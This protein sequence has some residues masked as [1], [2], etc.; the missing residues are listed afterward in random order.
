MF[1]KYIDCLKKEI[2]SDNIQIKEIFFI[3]LKAGRIDII[4]SLPS[5]QDTIK[6]ISAEELFDNAALA[7]AQDD[8]KLH[9]IKFLI[10]E[11][12]Y[13]FREIVDSDNI[14]LML[15]AAKNNATNIVKYLLDIGFNP[16]SQAPSGSTCLHFAAMNDNKELI[17]YLVNRGANLNAPNNMKHSPLI[18]AAHAASYVAMI[19][20]LRLGADNKITVYGLNCFQLF[21]MARNGETLLIKCTDT[22]KEPQGIFEVAEAQSA[23]FE[24]IFSNTPSHK[25]LQ[26]AIRQIEKAI[27]NGQEISIS[28]PTYLALVYGYTVI[29]SFN[30]KLVTN[31][32]K[33]LLT[34]HKNLPAEFF[35]TSYLNIGHKLKNIGEF[36]KIKP[37]INGATE[38]INYIKTKQVKQLSLSVLYYELAKLNQIFGFSEE[39]IQAYQLAIKYYSPS[40]E[41]NLLGEV[42]YGLGISHYYMLNENSSYKNYKLAYSYNKNSFKIFNAYISCLTIR[43]EYDKALKVIKA[44]NLPYTELYIIY[45]KFL[46]GDIKAKLALERINAEKYQNNQDIYEFALAI[47]S[48]CYHTLG[49]NKLAFLKMKESERLNAQV[50]TSAGEVFQFLCNTLEYKCEEE[51]LNFLESFKKTSPYEYQNSTLII[52][53]EALIYININNTDQAIQLINQ[54]SILNNKALNSHL[55]FNLYLNLTCLII[56]QEDSQKYELAQVYLERILKIDPSNEQAIFYKT[57][58]L[59][60]TGKAEQANQVLNEIDQNTIS[61]I[62]ESEDLIKTKA[63]EIKKEKEEEEEK[64]ENTEQ[65]IVKAEDFDPIKIH[66]Y[67]QRQK[68]QVL[69][70]AINAIKKEAKPLTSWHIASTTYNE[71]REDIKHISSNLFSDYYALINAKV[72]NKLDNITLQ[73]CYNALEKGICFRKTGQNGIKFIDG[74]IELKISEDIRLFT[75]RIYENEDGKKLII[76]DSIENHDSVKKVSSP[77]LRIAIEKVPNQDI[78]KNIIDADNNIEPLA[79]PTSF[80]ERILD[81]KNLEAYRA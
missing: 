55:L 22:S 81:R 26:T 16:N 20:L 37:L 15:K 34:K 7:I 64:L 13:D 3:L 46:K 70:N 73:R 78:G 27:N 65:E 29:N 75:S 52:I 71:G 53:V 41:K 28:E 25:K 54:L 36:D 51:G 19:E 49:D 14:N 35:I 11:C 61:Y 39:A 2:L 31:Y 58:I 12:E 48:K 6:P 56:E 68:K 23:Y 59:S 38:L 30:P 66:A 79:R 24:I 1:E 18:S 72:G 17:S 62:A 21:N 60:F 42:Y 80:V 45:I 57:L 69:V 9:V 8:N 32:L 40:D 4:K 50:Y 33:S 47:E 5:W 74:G 67:F 44:S 77:G 43:E 10:E 63:E 76:F